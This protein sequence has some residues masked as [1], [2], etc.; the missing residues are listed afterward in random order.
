MRLGESVTSKYLTDLADE[1]NEAADTF[2]YRRGG[3][4]AEH[5]GVDGYYV[6]VRKPGEPFAQNLDNVP[7]PR[8]PRARLQRGRSRGAHAGRRKGR[9]DEGGSCGLRG[10]ARPDANVTSSAISP[11]PLGRDHEVLGV[12]LEH[13][14]DAP[15]L[16]AVVGGVVRRDRI[17][18]AIS[19]GR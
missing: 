14:L 19:R 8:R 5:V 10:K 7:I 2:L 13:E 9:S 11:L 3:A 4:L 12:R 1:W 18:V 17:D 6:R 15:I 16:G